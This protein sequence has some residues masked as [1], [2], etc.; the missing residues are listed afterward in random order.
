[1]ILGLKKIFFPS[2]ILICQYLGLK[3]PLI[4]FS[5]RS[6][7]FFKVTIH[8]DCATKHYFFQENNII[9]GPWFHLLTF[10]FIDMTSLAWNSS[11]WYVKLS[12]TKSVVSFTHGFGGIGEFLFHDKSCH[13][14]PYVIT[15]FRSGCQVISV[16]L[17]WGS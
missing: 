7:A 12:K 10:S 16:F 15:I 11:S 9:T 14:Y 8:T 3:T 6:L 2:I 5:M 4:F 1:M 13:S 17:V